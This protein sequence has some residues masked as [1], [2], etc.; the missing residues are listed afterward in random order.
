MKTII[1]IFLLL[2]SNSLFP[3]GNGP[4][5]KYE[6]EMRCDVYPFDE[7]YTKGWGEGYYTYYE[8]DDG[9]RIKHGDYIFKYF[10]FKYAFFSDEDEWNTSISGKF[11]NGKKHGLWTV[12]RIEKKGSSIGGH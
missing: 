1:A 6:G 11:V 5:K 10:D 12:R 2:A 3:D 4:L 9:S 8:S 7:A